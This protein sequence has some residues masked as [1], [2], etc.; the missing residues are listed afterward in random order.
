MVDHRKIKAQRVQEARATRSA[1]LGD[2]RIP[3]RRQIKEWLGNQD[4]INWTADNLGL[5]QDLVCSRFR[6][7]LHEAHSD[8]CHDPVLVFLKLP[9]ELSFGI[10]MVRWVFWARRSE[11][12]NLTVATDYPFN[13]W[14]ES[15]VPQILIQ[16]R[17]PER[18]VNDFFPEPECLHGMNLLDIWQHTWDSYP[19]VRKP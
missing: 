8:P 12:P 7:L 3:S 19:E 9:Q 2:R 11:H 10:D 6:E 15:I 5:P 14:G 4:L 18:T 13:V 17:L 16:T 1:L